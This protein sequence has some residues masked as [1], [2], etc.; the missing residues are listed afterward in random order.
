MAQPN[1]TSNPGPHAQVRESRMMHL[2]RNAA[3]LAVFIVALLL[4][5][6]LQHKLNGY[7]SDLI[8]QCGIAIIMAVSLN[9][10]NGLTGQF[11]I[12]HAGFMAIGAYVGASVTYLAEMKFSH[13]HTPPDW[14]LFIAMCVGGLSAAICGL[15]VGI[16]SLRL[17]G[18]YLAIVTLGF[19]EIVRILI[20]NSASISPKLDLLG[21]ATGF[22]GYSGYYSVPH[23]AN[24]AFVFGSA[25]VVIWMSRNLKFSLQGLAFMSVR[26]DEIASEAM[27]V[28]TTRTK[29][30]AFFLSS[31]FAG[32]GGALF[33]HAEP[34]APATFSFVQ[35]M[36]YVIMVVLGGSGSISGATIAAIVLTLLPEALKP[37]QMKLGLADQYRLVLYAL[38]LV[39]MMILRPEG[40][41]GKSEIRF[42]R[43]KL[44]GLDNDLSPNTSTDHSS[45]PYRTVQTV[46][47]VSHLTRRFGGLL[48]VND[49]NIKLEDGDLVGLIGPNGAGK[50]TLFNLLTGVYS[51]TSGTVHFNSTMLAGVRT[52]S[53]LRRTILFIRDAFVGVVTGI[54]IGQIIVTSSIPITSS[55]DQIQAVRFLVDIFG[56][57]GGVWAAVYSIR[58]QK[59]LTPL[60]PHSFA[61][62][63]I[64]RTF[65]NIRLFRG[66]TVLENVCIGSYLRR[67]TSVID[68]LFRTPRVVQEEYEVVTNGR[69]LLDRFNLLKY[70]NA[71]VSNL[72]YGDQRRLE[73]V[74]ALATSPSILLLDEPAAGMN[75]QEKT[76]LMDLIR[77]IRDE[78]GLTVL[79]IEH[80]MKLV[81][82]V[83]ERIYV[84]DYGKIIAEGKPDEIKSDP[85]VIAAYLGEENAEN[86]TE[87]EKLDVE[88]LY[89]PDTIGAVTIDSVSSGEAE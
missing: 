33:A 32:L 64:A 16:P 62:T 73:I 10:V 56:L 44:A 75:P 53:F 7:I 19:G 84:L 68:A 31:F 66:L 67:R 18:D 35:S 78:F 39:V 25:F 29:I 3:F 30:T 45:L 48:A 42:L 27:G 41:F 49:V 5:N 46:L 87:S 65:Q 4:L 47:D 22:S 63:G 76:E 13:L 69:R 55:K 23:M 58:T 6:F 20:T 50:T 15:I 28:D 37:I 74:R 89:H 61:S 81:M 57:L 83:C 24:Y 54:I 36:N 2:A 11:S 70:E 21:G 40:V 60:K 72:P 34:F 52:A 88:Q 12:G 82:G 79:L 51:P 8:L 80:D 77:Q 17:R 9:I 86:E 43:R 38:M 71:L 14:W 59:N 1:I 26:E 85:K